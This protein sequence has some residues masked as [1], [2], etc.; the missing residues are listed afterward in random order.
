MWSNDFNRIAFIKERKVAVDF[1]RKNGFSVQ[2]WDAFV[3]EY[4]QAGVRAIIS[5]KGIVPS[6]RCP[7]MCSFMP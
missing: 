5:G 7:A 6:L 3:F 2:I 1:V 4:G